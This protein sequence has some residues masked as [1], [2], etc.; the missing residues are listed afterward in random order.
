MQF[1]L[2]RKLLRRLLGK[3]DIPIEHDD[4]ALVV[5]LRLELRISGGIERLDERDLV[6]TS[7]RWR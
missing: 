2:G 7:F 5:F 1:V 4:P 3:H 6:P